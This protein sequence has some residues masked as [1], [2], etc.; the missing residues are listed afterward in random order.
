MSVES[1]NVSG[2]MVI[3][4]SGGIDHHSAKDIRSKIDSEIV[5]N[6]PTRVVLDL[7][8]TTFMDSSGLGLVLGRFKKTSELNIPFEV[9]NPNTKIYKILKLAGVDKIVTIKGIGI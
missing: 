9:V 8:G 1:N 7:S 3:G 5:E 2:T 6:L 4:I